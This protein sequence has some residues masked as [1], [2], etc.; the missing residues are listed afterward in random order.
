[1]KNTWATRLAL[2]LVISTTICGYLANPTYKILTA[3]PD[4]NRTRPLA[5]YNYPDLQLEY[6]GLLIKN[7]HSPSGISFY[8][9]LQPKQ[10]YWLDVDGQT[11]KGHFFLAISQNY[12]EWETALPSDLIQFTTSQHDPIR[13]DVFGSGKGDIYKIRQLRFIPCDISQVREQKNLNIIHF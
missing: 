10:C 2:Y 5:L 7:D 3:I 12:T 11:L 9:R 8:Y 6:D 1:M 13:V 4:Q